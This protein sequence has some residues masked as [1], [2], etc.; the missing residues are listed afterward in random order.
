MFIGLRP[1][2]EE[3]E[4]GHPCRSFLSARIGVGCEREPRRG[5][6]APRREE[7]SS[8]LPVENIQIVLEIGFDGRPLTEPLARSLRRAFAE[9]GR[10]AWVVK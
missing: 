9:S 7:A 3:P 1:T 4:T 2:S 10:R 8:G 5:R 6:E